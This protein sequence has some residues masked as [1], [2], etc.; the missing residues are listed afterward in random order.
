MCSKDDIDKRKLFHQKRRL[1]LLLRHT[2]AHRNEHTFF[3]AL[4]FFQSPDI[5]ERMIF[6][7]LTDAAGIKYNDIRIFNRRFF[8]VSACP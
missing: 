3:M 8:R 6:C 1:A 4:E 7:V 5:S 2:S